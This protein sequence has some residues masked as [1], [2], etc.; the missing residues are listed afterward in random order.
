MQYIGCHLTISGGFAAMGRQAIELGG[1]TA[2]FF[3]RN[4]RGGRARE[5][6]MADIEALKQLMAEH[7]F[8]PLIAHAPYTINPCAANEKTLEFAHMA[9]ADDL[10]RLDFLP[11]Q[12][13]NFHPG[14]HVGQG[15]ETAAE[16]IANTLNA[17]MYPGQKTTVL[18]ETMAGKGSEVGGRFEELRAIIDRVALGD[19]IGVCLD[20]CHVS[21]AGYDIVHD[22]DG[23]LTEFD[24]IIGLDRLKALHLNDSM[25]PTGSRKDRHQKLGKGFL[26]LEVFR[27]IVNH[28]ALRD[29]PKVLETPNE[30]QGYAEEIRLLREMA[31]EDCTMERI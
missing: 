12:Y 29:L 26:G 1:N 6:D 4:P 2:Q 14:S 31:G 3:T 7:S 15:I 22:L 21:D 9:M 28:P 18:L 30:P 23:V 27:N 24:K 16:K 25:N 11:G 17:V 19:K 10:R 5:L 8:G 13:Y 20:T